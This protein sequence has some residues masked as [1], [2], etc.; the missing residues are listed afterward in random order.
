[1][2]KESP[3][4]SPAHKAAPPSAGASPRHA[5]VD[6]RHAAYDSAAEETLEIQYYDV[7]D[8]ER[9]HKRRQ[10]AAEVCDRLFF[11]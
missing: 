7:D 8:V 10:E 4:A 5:W 9:I 11:Q 6:T 3:A 1:M 2:H